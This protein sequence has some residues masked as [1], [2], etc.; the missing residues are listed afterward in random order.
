VSSYFYAA[1]AGVVICFILWIVRNAHGKRA[2]WITSLMTVFLVVAVTLAVVCPEARTSDAASAAVVQYDDSADLQVCF[3]DVGQADSILITCQGHAM[4]I[5]AGTN[6][7]A[8]T[9]V[10]FLKEKGI[11]TLDYVVGT[12]PHED[13]IGGMDAVI[14][15]FD[16]KNVLM[17]KV[18]TDTKT[19]EDVLDAVSDKGLQI[20]APSQGDTYALGDAELTAENCL[21]PDDNDLN[22]SSIVL[23]LDF[24]S[25]SV[26][27]TG[28]SGESAEQAILDSGTDID[29]DVL[30]VGHHGSSDSTSQAF[31]N[32]V[33]PE[34][35]V[36]SC[37]QDNDYGHPAADTLDRLDAAGVKLFRTD[38]QGTVV[39]SS[40]GTKLAWST[41]PVADTAANPG[42]AA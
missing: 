35:A 28:D 26:L 20:T 15:N 8:D 7:A 2:R 6:D 25:V 36:I 13:H 34:Y 38:E 22:N 27:F 32:A 12:H 41:D 17:P 40:D 10:S 4:L 5:D 23:R 19:F 29:C 39:L 11:T 37:G 21:A 30:K 9:V 16:V 14:E 3:L 42:K 18:E 24:G 1:A 31:L 33:T